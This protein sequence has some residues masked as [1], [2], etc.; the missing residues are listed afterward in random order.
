MYRYMLFSDKTRIYIKKKS[1]IRR[2]EVLIKREKRSVCY[3]RQMRKSTTIEKI[4]IKRKISIQ[5]DYFLLY[6]KSKYP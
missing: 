1:N 2:L 5:N 3:C 4:R 6:Y